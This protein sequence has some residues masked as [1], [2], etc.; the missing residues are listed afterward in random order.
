MNYKITG[1]IDKWAA[2]VT[3]CKAYK[4]L[5]KACAKFTLAKID[6]KMQANEHISDIE[7]LAAKKSIRLL[8]DP[9][10]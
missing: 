3:T 8:Q 7:L 2:R 6:K 1:S 4:V 10:F 9:D 5:A